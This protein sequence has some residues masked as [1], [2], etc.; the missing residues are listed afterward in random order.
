MTGPTTPPSVAAVM[1]K[2]SVLP[3]DVRGSCSDSIEIQLLS[4][5]P[6]GENMLTPAD[7]AK[8]AYTSTMA[9]SP[10]LSTRYTATNANAAHRQRPS[11]VTLVEKLRPLTVV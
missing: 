7:F 1:L 2:M 9:G 6:S 4:V 8:L 3:I 10:R 11:R 5:Y